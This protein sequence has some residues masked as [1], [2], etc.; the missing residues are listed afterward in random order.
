MKQG[1]V[2]VG[3]HYLAKVSGKLVTVEVKSAKQ[4]Y[5]LGSSR[6]PRTRYVC[7]NLHTNREIIVTAARLR[8]KLGCDDCGTN[9]CIPREGTW[10]SAVRAEVR[11]QEERLLTNATVES[12]KA[13]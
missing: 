8:M 9:S 5:V 13:N 10:C 12:V 11:R 7:V 6:A 4:T 3:D 1:L 2:R